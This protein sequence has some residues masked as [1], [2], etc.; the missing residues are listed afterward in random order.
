MHVPGRH[1]RTSG[2][3]D[4]AGL[5]DVAQ[6][7]SKRGPVLALLLGLR[8]VLPELAPGPA[9]GGEPGCGDVGLLLQT[10]RGAGVAGGGRY[11]SCRSRRQRAEPLPCKYE[12]AE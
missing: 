2:P 4:R 5:W 1:L 6:R 11:T 10:T 12:E 8:P 9:R 7:L 3:A